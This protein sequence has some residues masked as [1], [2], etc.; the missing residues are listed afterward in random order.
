M[1]EL[2]LSPESAKSWE[3]KAMEI[4]TLED[5]PRLIGN[6]MKKNKLMIDYDTE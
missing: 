3:W 2:N 1:K 4:V 6:R 5:K